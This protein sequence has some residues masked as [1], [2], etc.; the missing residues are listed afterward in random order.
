SAPDAAL[1][2]V[3]RYTHS[4]RFQIVDGYKTLSM[5]WHLADTVQTI[6]NGLAWTP[7]FKPVLK[8]MGVD[9]A[10]IMDFHGDGHPAISRICASTSFTR[11]SQRSVRSRIQISC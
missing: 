2:D 7:P 5:H 6:A 1:A 8:A 4:D 3:L 11:T 9:A 10:I